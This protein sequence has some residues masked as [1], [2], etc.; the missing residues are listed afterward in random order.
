MKRSIIFILIMIFLGTSIVM[1]QNIST[2]NVQNLSD[3][4]IASIV[5]QVQSSG[6][7]MDQA[8][9][10]AKAKGATQTQISQLMSR[11]QQLN[12]GP[13]GTTVSSSPVQGGATPVVYSTKAPVRAG[14]T[15]KRVFGYQLFNNIKLSFDPSVNLPTPKNYVLGTGDQLFINVWGASQQTY[16][17]AVD[18]SGAIYIPSL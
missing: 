3:S 7:S 6:L 4:Q 14:T 2:T 15:A 12:P 11:I 18:K 17:L 10:L 5:K 13:Q 8:I 9:T 16:Q 1:A